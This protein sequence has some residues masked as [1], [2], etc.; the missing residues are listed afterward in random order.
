MSKQ[1]FESLATC[2]YCGNDKPDITTVEAL[3]MTLTDNDSVAC[4]TEGCPIEGVKM[5]VSQ[6]N[7]RYVCPDKHGNPVYAGDKVY[8]GSEKVIATV[9]LQPTAKLKKTGLVVGISNN[10]ELVQATAKGTTI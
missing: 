10:V 8:W 5:L 2:P 9:S 6:W 7:K 1:E 3:A 4:T